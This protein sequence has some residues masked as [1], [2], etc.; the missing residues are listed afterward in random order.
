MRIHHSEQMIDI[1]DPNHECEISISRDGNG[2]VVWVNVDGIC[3]L[4]VSRLSVNKLAVNSPSE[5]V[6]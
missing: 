4:R 2:V 6:G 3:R 1:S 5:I